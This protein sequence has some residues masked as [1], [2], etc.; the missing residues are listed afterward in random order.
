MQMNSLYLTFQRRI[1][2]ADIRKGNTRGFPVV[3][4]SLLKFLTFP[5]FG[6]FIRFA[7]DVALP[8]ATQLAVLR[9]MFLIRRLCKFTSFKSGK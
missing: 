4:S 7:R 2:K 6:Q 9:I 5:V 1:F 8:E 3:N